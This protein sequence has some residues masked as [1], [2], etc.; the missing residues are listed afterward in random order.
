MSVKDISKQIE[1]LEKK[2]AQNQGDLDT[3]QAELQ[4][5]KYLAF[6]EE[7]HEEDNRK[8]LQG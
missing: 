8:L 1:L 7:F 5:L 6:E 4:R 3:M 2:I